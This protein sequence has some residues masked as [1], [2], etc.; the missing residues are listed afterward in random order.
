MKEMGEERSGKGRL[1][2]R[3]REMYIVREVRVR[4]GRE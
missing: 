3:E 4:E 1:K 2:E